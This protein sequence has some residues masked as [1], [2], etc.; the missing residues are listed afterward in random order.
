MAQHLVATAN[1]HDRT[2]FLRMLQNLPGPPT[3]TQTGQISQCGLGTGEQ[4]NIGLGQRFP[5]QNGNNLHPR[6]RTKRVQI[7][8]IGNHGQHGHNHAQTGRG[9]TSTTPQPSCTQG[10]HQIGRV[11]GWQVMHL[12]QMWHQP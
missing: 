9:T 4:N 7:I 2:A 12:W 6:L 8:K 11:L 1:T 3:C 10:V 5:F